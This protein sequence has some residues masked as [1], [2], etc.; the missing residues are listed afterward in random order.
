MSDIWGTLYLLTGPI[1]I[2]QGIASQWL[3]ISQAQ[4]SRI[5]VGPPLQDLQRLAQWATVLR[6]PRELL[7]FDLPE[8]GGDL[9]RRQFLIASGTTVIGI[10]PMSSPAHK[11]CD[12]GSPTEQDCAQWL[13]WELWQRH[14]SSLSTTDLPRPIAHVLK[15]A[16]PVG[17]A[18]LRDLHGN[19]SF[20]HPS[21][22]D[23]FVAQRIFDEI[24]RGESGLLTTAQTSHDTDQIL[25]RFVIHQTAS[26]KAL[27]RWMRDGSTSILRVNSAGILAKIGTASIADDVIMALKS[28]LDARHLYLT[29]VASR[30]LTLPWEAASQFAS[31]GYPGR[32][33]VGPS[34]DFMADLAVRLGQEIQD[35]QDGAARWC[36]VVLLGRMGRR[37][38]AH[39]T[40]ALQE[41]LRN[42]P[43]RENLRAIGSALSYSDPIGI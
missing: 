12:D 20:A 2:S 1:H 7:W 26:V 11:L 37:L 36:S 22:V 23:F 34:E 15:D 25:R 18:I 5:E 9:K 42:E 29:A 19:Y 8:D 17:G 30:V 13:A 28:D 33:A 32:I 24:V 43:C 31:G 14:E 16:P 10:P 4:L 21:L 40:S 3:G 6:I 38:P 35:S 41:A 27:T 39:V